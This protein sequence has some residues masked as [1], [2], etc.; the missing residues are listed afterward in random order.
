MANSQG[1]NLPPPQEPF[2]EPARILSYTGYQYL[3]SL[4]QAAAALT[5]T[6]TIAPNVAATGNNQVTALQLTAQN[7]TVTS[8]KN[9][10]TGVMLA[11]LQPG[12]SQ[13][14]RNRLAVTLNVFPPPGAQIEAL[15]I[16]QLQT[17]ASGSDLTFSFDTTTQIRT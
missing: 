6:A 11:A 10:G 5:P 16:N 4:L 3:L 1:F 14:V 7:N 8:Q 9:G 13:I 17:I 2:V 12:Q 15:G